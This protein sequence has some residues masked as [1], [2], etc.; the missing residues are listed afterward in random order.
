MDARAFARRRTTFSG[1]NSC[2]AEEQTRRFL[3]V[4]ESEIDFFGLFRVVTFFAGMFEQLRLK[5]FVLLR[6]FRSAIPTY[7]TLLHCIHTTTQ[8]LLLFQLM[9][10]FDGKV[11]DTCPKLLPQTQKQADPKQLKTLTEWSSN[12]SR[13]LTCPWS[14]TWTVAPKRVNSWRCVQSM[15]SRACL[16][17]GGRISMKP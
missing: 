12:S 2:W 1:G 10:V 13:N 11:L 17:L 6:A 16:D 15:Q 3:E 4:V 9:K 14:R 7:L 5:R 8:L